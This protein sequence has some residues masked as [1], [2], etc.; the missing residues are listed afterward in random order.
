MRITV[1]KV[2][3]KAGTEQWGIKLDTSVPKEYFVYYA[4]LYLFDSQLGSYFWHDRSYRQF[5]E[6]LFLWIDT[7]DQQMIDKSIMN[8]GLGFW[9]TPYTILE[10]K[11]IETLV[12]KN[13]IQHIFDIINP[14]KKIVG[15]RYFKWNN[16]K[17]WYCKYGDIDVVIDN[18]Q[19]WPTYAQAQQAFNRWMRVE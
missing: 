7:F 3:S 2:L 4:N 17:H 5:Y 1:C 12:V 19:S 18:R 11:V 14:V 15:P 13:P 16:G 6:W 8:R 10:E 9:V